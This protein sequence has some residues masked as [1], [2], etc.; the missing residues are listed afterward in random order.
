MTIAYDA[1]FGIHA[2][3]NWQLSLKAYDDGTILKFV[4]G[5]EGCTK[6]STIAP[7]TYFKVR[8]T[9]VVHKSMYLTKMIQCTKTGSPFTREVEWSVENIA[10]GVAKGEIEIITKD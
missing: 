8:A 5:Y 3:K 2:Y 6:K 4:K 10:R 7:G 1:S 9:E